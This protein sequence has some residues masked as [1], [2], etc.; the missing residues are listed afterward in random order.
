MPVNCRPPYPLDRTTK[1]QYFGYWRPT[2]P[3]CYCSPLRLGNYSRINSTAVLG[4]SSSH[5][6]TLLTKNQACSS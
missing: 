2:G 4:W 1:P 3:P 6:S 5:E